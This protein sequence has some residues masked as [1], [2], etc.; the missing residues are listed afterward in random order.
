MFFLSLQ[1]VDN[2]NPLVVVSLA[3]GLPSF[4]IASIIGPLIGGAF[5][6]DVSWRWCFYINLP[7]G[8]VALA[9]IAAFQPA[10][11]PLGRAASY[12]GYSKQMFWQVLKC[13]WLGVALTI[14][15][16]TCAILF[17]QWGGATK[18]WNDGSVIALIVLTVVI[19]P[20]FLLYEWWLKDNAMF[21]IQLMKRRT[22]A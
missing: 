12:K 3:D 2:Y 10:A 15:W 9:M 19:P 8:G 21:R 22:I 18:P 16:G 1:L 20:I 7:L 14:G 11:P 6:D 4:A 13:D 5:S 17:M